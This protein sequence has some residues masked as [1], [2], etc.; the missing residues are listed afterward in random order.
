MDARSAAASQFRL[1]AAPAGRTYSSKTA[2]ASSTNGM[3]R[4]S[5]APRAPIAPSS[6]CHRN[7]SPSRPTAIVARPAP[8]AVPRA[9]WW[10]RRWPSSCATTS[11]TSRG[12]TRR[13]VVFDTL[14]QRAGPRDVRLASATSTS[15]TG[16]PARTDRAR[17]SAANSTSARGR[18]RL[19]SGSSTTGARNDSTT[20]SAAAHAPATAGQASGSAEASSTNPSITAPVRATDTATPL[21]QSHRNAGNACVENPHRCSWTNP[22]QND[23]GKRSTAAVTR[24][25][26]AYDAAKAH[27]GRSSTGTA[28]HRPAGENANAARYPAPTAEDAADD[29]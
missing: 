22:R 8:S 4:G 10:A 24:I 13:V 5:P 25:S 28:I 7:T 29:T 21:A 26:A 19:N 20:T 11:R 14:L 1:I 15:L 16:T 2:A 18:N 12:R 9:T 17:R 23:G 3:A 6:A 27:F